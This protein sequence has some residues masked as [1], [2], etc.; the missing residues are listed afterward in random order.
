[1]IYQRK[2]TKVRGLLTESWVDRLLKMKKILKS[3]PTTIPSEGNF[4]VRTAN[5]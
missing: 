2:K 5:N 4:I 1:M 3:D